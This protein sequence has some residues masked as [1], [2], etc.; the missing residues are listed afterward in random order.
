M[1]SVYRA[2]GLFTA[3]SCLYLTTAVEGSGVRKLLIAALAMARFFVML[4]KGRVALLHVHG[5][6]H[7]SFWRKQV[8]M[9][10]ARYFEVPVIFHLHGGEFRQ[11]V[12]VR[13][14]TRARR[15]VVEALGACRLILCLNEEVRAWLQALVPPVTVQVMPNPIDL[16][17]HA[18]SGV[19]REHRVLYL[20]RLERDKGVFD[21]LE[22]FANVAQHMPQSHLTLC[23]TG[24]AK[25]ELEKWVQQNGIATQVTFPG[26]VDG[27][28]KD[29]LLRQ[30]GVF[31]LPSYA[32]GMPMAVLECMAAQTPVVATR[33]G[34]IAD[35]LESGASGIVVEPRD[36]G[37][38]GDAILWA[39]T[40][41]ETVGAMTQRALA[42]VHSRY[43]ANVVV[44]QLRRIHQEMSV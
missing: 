4:L 19:V 11:F 28:A 21:L 41:K 9:R 15:R 1:V 35:M 12:D 25:D 44:S 40:D 16:R 6:S 34:A 13:I 42:R 31:V 5:A 17:A 18:Q 20:G 33:V 37:A 27:D 3:D 2:N 23:G 8:F 26:W 22:A 29:M 32:E 14:S 24:S 10:M 30:A 7:S 36:I 39:L 43:A 38:L